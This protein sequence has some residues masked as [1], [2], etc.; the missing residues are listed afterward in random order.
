MIVGFLK[1]ANKDLKTEK[2]VS[3]SSESFE[4][5]KR[6]KSKEKLSPIF[7]DLSKLNC[8]VN[9]PIEA[10]Y[11]FQKSAVS[12]TQKLK[13]IKVQSDDVNKILM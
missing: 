5:E 13:K 2:I 8:F 7:N 4:I 6:S 1:K 11:F 10:K 3:D 9:L 12:R